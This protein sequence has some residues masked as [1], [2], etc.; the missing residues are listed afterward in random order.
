MNKETILEIGLAMLITLEAVHSAGYVFNDLKLDN[1]MI[2]INQKVLK[3]KEG[4]SM[5]SQCSI[6]LVDFGY[7]TKYQDNLGKHIKEDT[8][9]NFRGNLMFASSS[10]LDFCTT[11]RRDDLIS[12]CYILIFLLN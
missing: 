7:A 8:I 10:S 9:E 12:L 4:I 6:H 3:P 11:S 1:L 2:G 5:F